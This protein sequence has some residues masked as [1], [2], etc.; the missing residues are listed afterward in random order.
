MGVRQAIPVAI[1]VILAA[2]VVALVLARLAAGPESP[3]GGVMVATTGTTFDPL[4]S[5]T[6]PPPTAAQPPER[7][8]SR[9]GELPIHLQPI[10]EV[11][12]TDW[13]MRTI[14][15]EELL[16]GIPAHDP[17][18]LIRPI[19]DP[20]FEDID[21]AEDWLGSNEPGVRL[22]VAGEAR[23]YPLRIMTV[24]EVVNDLVGGIPVAVTYCPL[25]NTAAVFDRQVEGEVLRFG[26]SGL[27]RNSDLVMWD[28]STDSL[29]LSLEIS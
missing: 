15:L 16:V 2:V 20:V 8:G 10:V 1:G 9:P 17:R 25:C 27:L 6:T 13:S 29:W 24:H 12:R 22:V 5:S 14:E 11:W 26:V 18:D 28:D 3:T 21:S 19:D 23:F 7:V 4:G